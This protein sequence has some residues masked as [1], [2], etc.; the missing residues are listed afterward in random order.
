MEWV[1]LYQAARIIKS[2]RERV[3][4]LARQGVVESKVDPEQRNRKLYKKSDLENVEL[5]VEKS[6]TEILDEIKKVEQTKRERKQKKPAKCEGCTWNMGKTCMF[7]RCVKEEGWAYQ[8]Y[9]RSG[10]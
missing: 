6:V 3:W 1:Q 2:S 10:E 8:K 9:K 4:K 5:R 7:N